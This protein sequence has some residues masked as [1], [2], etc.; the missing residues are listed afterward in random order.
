MQN[1]NQN[2]TTN[3]S[4]ALAAG[5]GGPYLPD[6]IDLI[7]AIHNT[8]TVH[9]QGGGQ[10]SAPKTWVRPGVR[11]VDARNFT[12]A[13]AAAG[14]L[15]EH[16]RKLTLIQRISAVLILITGLSTGFTFNRFLTQ[17]AAPPS[18]RIARAAP[19]TQWTVERIDGQ[20]IQ[21]RIKS[22]RQTPENSTSN[23]VDDLVR[24]A[25]G[26]HL[27][28]G[29]TLLSVNALNAEYSTTQ[30]VTRLRAALDVDAAPLTES[31]AAGAVKDYPVRN[32]ATDLAAPT[33]NPTTAASAS[34]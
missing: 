25:I 4:S 23:T 8:D 33:K 34:K 17:N 12:S 27:P 7:A 9:L 32:D 21:V 30:G 16:Q 13:S 10:D 31:G 22:L 15:W 6:P 5:P 14:L 19:P 11:F 28:N 2:T 20:A 26:E 18:V 24:I 3:P 1:L 29:D